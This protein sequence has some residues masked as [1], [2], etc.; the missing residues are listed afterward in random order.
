MEPE[1]YQYVQGKVERIPFEIWKSR[2]F[3][4]AS[5]IYTIAKGTFTTT[6]T[7][8][9]YYKIMQELMDTRNKGN[10]IK[11]KMLVNFVNQK[12][13]TWHVLL[14]TLTQEV[15]WAFR[16]GE[17]SQAEKLFIEYESKT[18]QCEENLL[19]PSCMGLYIRSANERAKE[20]Y[21]KAFDLAEAS[22]QC[23]EG[24]APGLI[25]AWCYTNVAM[26]ASTLANKEKHDREI[27][28]NKAKRSF[29]CALQYLNFVKPS[30]EFKT[31]VSDLLLK[32]YIHLSYLYLGLSINGSLAPLTCV[33]IEDISC[34]EKC[35]HEVNKLEKNGL[36]L[37]PVR[38][39][40]YQL[41]LSALHFRKFQHNLPKFDLKLLL[42]SCDKALNIATNNN[43][44]EMIRSCE[45]LITVLRL[46]V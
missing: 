31:A 35:L 5:A 26:I 20:E 21:K 37:T 22:L 33:S 2:I 46:P 40:Q 4:T 7:E 1:S 19:I 13:K 44:K 41:A 39:I 28:I 24:I 12:Y 27:Y 30:E 6:R 10:E 17:F 36:E 11:F 16:K 25:Q 23:A 34:A 32:I 8:N 29:G 9:I 14:T 43:F 38:N 18:S 42:G 15:T 45:E 3:Q